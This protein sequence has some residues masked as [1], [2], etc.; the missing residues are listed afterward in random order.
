MRLE[1]QNGNTVIG[2]V[3]YHP[4]DSSL[5]LFN[6]NLDTIPT[7][8]LSPINAIIDPFE[9]PVDSTYL[10]V[11]AGT[12]YLILHDIGSSDNVESAI[13]WH[14][15]NGADLV[16]HKNDIIEFN[17][18]NWF[19]SFNAAGQDDIKYCTNLKS[20]IQFKWNPKT[21]NWSKSVEGRY[22]PGSWAIVLTF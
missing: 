7:S 2:T 14:G 22:D 16:A 15:A 11:S 13:A 20:G 21:Q 18:T 9:M 5:L 6:P 8:S 3:S 4:T 19:V 12:R 17:G 1:Q 10:N